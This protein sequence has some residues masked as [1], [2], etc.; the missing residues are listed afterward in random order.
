MAFA[1]SAPPNCSDTDYFSLC[2]SHADSPQVCACQVKV[3]H[4]VLTPEEIKW[5]CWF[6]SNPQAAE[7][8][9][10][11]FK[12]PEKAEALGMRLIE[13]GHLINQRCAE[14]R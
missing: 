3:M 6:Q 10:E 9:V 7:R 12:E 8:A 5:A 1:Q 4:D 2:V 11:A 13:R 14:L